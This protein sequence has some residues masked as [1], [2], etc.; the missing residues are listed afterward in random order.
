VLINTV[1]WYI[2]N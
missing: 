1:M 2:F